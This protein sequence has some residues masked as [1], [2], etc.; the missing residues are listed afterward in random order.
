M[1]RMRDVARFGLLFTPS[2]S[3]VSDE[4]IISERYLELIRN[5]GN[6]K[7]LENSPWGN[8]RGKDVKHNVY[9][10]DRVFTN[11]DFYK[12]GWAG[13]GLL[14]NADE[15]WVAV[16]SGYY[17]EDGSEVGLLPMVRAI[18]QGVYGDTAP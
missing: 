9:Q 3:V 8:I 18:L 5:G 14:I 12:G 6:P 4:K 13:Q 16:W 17:A 11:N 2:Y 1:A 15:D 10:W 7:L